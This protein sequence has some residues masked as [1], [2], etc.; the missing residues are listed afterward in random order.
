MAAKDA[1]GAYGE[2]VAARHLIEAGMVVLARNWRCADGEL[3]IVAR[4]GV[5]LVFCEV[6]TRRS[7]RFGTPA[8]AIGAVKVQR[9]RRLACEWI[10]ASG[11]STPS[12]RFDVVSVRPQASGAAHI[13]HLKDAF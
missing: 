1:V 13:E 10:R 7:E 11:L 9:L 12:M 5:I 4:D 2:R 8:E 6:K 3:D